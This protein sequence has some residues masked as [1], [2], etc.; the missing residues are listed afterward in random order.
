MN[1]RIVAVIGAVVLALVGVVLLAAYARDADDR[2]F[3]GA[4]LASVLQVKEAI[5]ADTKTEDVA[6]KVELVKLPRTAIADGAISDLSEVSGLKT[7]VGLEPGEQVLSSRFSETGSGPEVEKESPGGVPKGYQEVTIQLALAQAGGGGLKPG[8]IVG[9]VASYPTNDTGGF[10]Q[11][12]K[13]FVRVTR[14]V[15]GVKA[16]DSEDVGAQQLVTLAVMTRDAGRVINA[17]EFGKVWL[18][19]Q[20]KD[21]QTGNGGSVTKSEVTK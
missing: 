15:G 10:T 7:A 9:V 13:N 12:A 3:D 16:D 19:Q 2:A 14:V 4:E 11:L 8:D 21:T 20:N 17:A 6:G 5:A 18:T 1:K